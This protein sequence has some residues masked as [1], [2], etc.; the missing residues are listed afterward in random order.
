MKIF[1]I[2]DVHGD[3]SAMID[4]L[5]SKGFDENNDNHLLV[6]IGDAFDRGEESVAIYE[7]LKRLSDKSK[8]IVLKGNHTRF[9]TEYLDGTSI[10][11]F[12][13]LHNGTDK[14]LDDFLHQ[15]K[16]FYSWCLLDKSIDEPTNKDFADWI[17]YARKQINKEYPELLSWLEERPYYFETKN[18]IFTHGSIDTN[19]LDWHEPHCQ[20]FGLRDWEALMFDDGSFFNKEITN[21]KKTVV[22]GHFHTRNLRQTYNIND[23]SKNIDDILIRDDNKIIAIDGCTSLTH[24]VNVLVIE[25]ELL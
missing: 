24:N 11:P 7:Y 22:I 17:K 18:F 2:S 15:T 20:R 6:S 8:A 12:N 23:N 3:Y 16:S 1:A 13:W 4:C 9:F 5:I 14:T 19:A 10:S 25:D 21:T